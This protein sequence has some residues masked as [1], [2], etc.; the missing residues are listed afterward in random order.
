MFYFCY[1]TYSALFHLHD[2]RASENANFSRILLSVVSFRKD[3]AAQPGKMI[4]NRGSWGAES[5]DISLTKSLLSSV[6]CQCPGLFLPA[7][8]VHVC[9]SS[10][11]YKG[12]HDPH[13]ATICLP[14]AGGLIGIAA[15]Y[16]YSSLE[17][18]LTLISGLCIQLFSS[19]LFTY[20]SRESVV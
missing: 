1:S 5:A 20:T 4:G 8:I 3:E 11:L 13:R 2:C 16:G 15:R 10:F 7:K 18:V 17:D 14:G 19:S 12:S 6:K 9:D